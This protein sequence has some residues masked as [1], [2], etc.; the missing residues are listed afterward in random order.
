MNFRWPANGGLD[1]SSAAE[2]N[3]SASSPIQTCR[4][5]SWLLSPFM[6]TE[7][8]LFAMYIQSDSGGE[9]QKP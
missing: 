6:A 1:V 8:F 4:Q 9:M 5:V 2:G 7:T 3:T